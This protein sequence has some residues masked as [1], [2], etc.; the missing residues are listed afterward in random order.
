MNSDYEKELLEEIDRKLKSLPELPA[1]QT[2]ALRVMAAIQAR[3]ALPWYQR[4]WQ[5]WP[6]ALRIVSMGVL[7]TVFGGL[8]FGAWKLA[9]AEAVLTAMGKVGG[10]FAYVSALWNALNAV[11][12]GL[13]LLAKQLGTGFLIGCFA[14]IAVGY[15]LCI[16]LGSIYVRLA[17]AT[18]P[19]DD[20]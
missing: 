20:L 17:L 5:A 9:Q 3:A 2:L 1:P 11:L 15:A 10:L 12:G 14:A 13:V 18:K 19:N 16:G 6:L 8:C 7:M 4:S